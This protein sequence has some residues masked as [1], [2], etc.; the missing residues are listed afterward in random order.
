MVGAISGVRP[1]R[2]ETVTAPPSGTGAGMSRH[3]R[4]TTAV[5]PSPVGGDFMQE[6][7]ERV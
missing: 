1:G 6:E 7:E 4:D 5:A 2:A 3:K